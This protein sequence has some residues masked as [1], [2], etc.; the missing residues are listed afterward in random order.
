LRIRQKSFCAGWIARLPAPFA[1][2][3]NAAG[4]DGPT[5]RSTNPRP[6]TSKAIRTAT[7]AHRQLWRLRTFMESIV[8]LLLAER[9]ITG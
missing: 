8:S 4:V 7:A 2:D 5:L 9:E 3:G 6:R 1:A